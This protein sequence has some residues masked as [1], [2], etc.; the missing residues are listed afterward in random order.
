[1]C[2][3]LTEELFIV[4]MV[5]NVILYRIYKLIKVVKAILYRPVKLQALEVH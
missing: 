2:V 3:Y 4:F 5:I 1:M